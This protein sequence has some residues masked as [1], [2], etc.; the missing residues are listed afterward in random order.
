MRRRLSATKRFWRSWFSAIPGS[1]ISLTGIPTSIAM[2]QIS[3]RIALH[4]DDAPDGKT[5][6]L[7]FPLAWG[8]KMIIELNPGVAAAVARSRFLT[9][10]RQVA[11]LFLT[12]STCEGY[13][14]NN[15]TSVIRQRHAA[16]FLAAVQTERI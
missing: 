10:E 5:W 16:H 1:T 4:L 7:V 15:H 6:K 9:V 13:R 11:V 8:L 14:Q 2:S 12:R 3:K